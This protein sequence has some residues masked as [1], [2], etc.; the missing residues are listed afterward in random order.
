[1]LKKRLITAA[2]LIPVF[3]LAVLYL[4]NQYF[5]LFVSITVTLGAIEWSRLSGFSSKLSMYSYAA[6]L[7][8]LCWYLLYFISLQHQLFIIQLIP[9]CWLLA[10]ALV[11]RYEFKPFVLP[12]QSFWMLVIGALVLI[13]AWLGLVLLHQHVEMMW[14]LLLFAIIWG[15][16]S[17]AYFAGKQWGKH[18]LA[19]H[20]SPG[21]SWEGAIAAIISTFV[22]GL[23][24]SFYKQMDNNHLPIFLSIC[25]LTVLS[26]ILGDLFESLIK[27]SAQIKD[28]G[29]ILPGHGGVLDRIDSMTAAAPVFFCALYWSGYWS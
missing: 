21:K 17:V 4:P 25:I 16:D 7:T 14:V 18:R 23:V 10:L 2:I 8:G 22:I 9:V 19:S 1:M 13:P 5:A 6:L 20:V 29:G 12:Q 15:A 27:R 11:T 28:S 26:S 3:V 24:Y